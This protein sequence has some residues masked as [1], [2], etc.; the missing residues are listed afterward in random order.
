MVS[1][2][3]TMLMAILIAGGGVVGSVR[4]A[5][6]LPPPVFVLERYETALTQVP[7]DGFVIVSAKASWCTT[8]ALMNEKSWRSPMVERW[9]DDHHALAVQ[10]DVTDRADLMQSLEITDV[11]TVLVFRGGHEVD[12]VVGF[13]TD[14]ELVEWFD[15]LQD[16]RRAIDQLRGVAGDR[17]SADG[18]VDIRR[19]IEL[20]R[21]RAR[22]GQDQSAAEEYAWLWNHMLTFDATTATLR[23]HEMVEDMSRLARQSNEAHRVFSDLRETYQRAVDVGKI[24]VEDLR[25]WILLNDIVQDASRTLIWYEG[26]RLD[27]H[28]V[29]LVQAVEEEV[30]DRFLSNDRWSDAA[31]MFPDPVERI[32]L[33]ITSREHHRTIRRMWAGDEFDQGDHPLA[34][35]QDA[36]FRTYVSKIYAVC[37]ASKQADE[38]AAIADLLMT[39]DASDEMRIQLIRMALEAG[40]PRATHLDWLEAATDD[41]DDSLA[42]RMRVTRALKTRELGSPLGP[43]QPPSRA[44][45]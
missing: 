34:A 37:L 17:M 18:S 2:L 15:G 7:A 3:H 27:P 9:V 38:A 8:S 41:P 45:R 40:E 20:A 32:R 12:R 5:A 26:S 42:L 39:Y 31:K 30:F 24:D 13:Q 19:R 14:R 22:A 36:T 44:R 35:A 29:R 43:T 1:W 10:I 4:G 16:G 28:R 33:A 21:A 11:P 6:V 25:D 23:Q